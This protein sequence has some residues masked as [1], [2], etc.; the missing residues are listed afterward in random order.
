L[1]A[2]RGPGPSPRAHRIL[3]LLSCTVEASS[4]AP[5]GNFGHILAKS[6]ASVGEFCTKHEQ[7]KVCKSKVQLKLIFHSFF[8]RLRFDYSN[9]PFWKKGSKFPEIQS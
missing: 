3:S 6:V 9:N 8:R 4:F 1:Y 5:H 7:N 2:K